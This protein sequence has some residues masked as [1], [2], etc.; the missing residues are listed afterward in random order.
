VTSAIANEGREYAVYLLHGEPEGQWGC[1]FVVTSGD[2][3][4]EHLALYPV[5]AGVWVAEWVD[6]STGA[7]SR[8]D[9]VEHGGGALRLAPPPYRVD[10]ALLLRRSARA[11]RRP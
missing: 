10:L 4:G 3:T 1:H 11:R 7:V 5:P 9:A 2:W 6:P 8:R